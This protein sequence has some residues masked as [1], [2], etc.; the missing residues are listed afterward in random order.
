MSI[1]SNVRLHEGGTLSYSPLLW[2]LLKHHS[3]NISTNYSKMQLTN[4][5][6]RFNKGKW[7]PP[8]AGALNCGY[9][10]SVGWVRA[11][12]LRSLLMDRGDGTESSSGSVVMFGWGEACRQDWCQYWKNT[13]E[14][15][16]LLPPWASAQAVFLSCKGWTI[17]YCF[18]TD[19]YTKPP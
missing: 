16:L 19:I 17:F 8:K 9:V 12:L 1:I 2:S 4:Q 10:T 18:C 13:G 6:E 7:M 11:R 15:L 14:V 3:W 5:I